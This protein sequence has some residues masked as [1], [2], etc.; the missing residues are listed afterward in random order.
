LRSNGKGEG[1]SS[2]GVAVKSLQWSDLSGERR[3]PERAGWPYSTLALR[4]FVTAKA[5]LEL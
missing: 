3:E 4:A 1:V 5:S 2:D